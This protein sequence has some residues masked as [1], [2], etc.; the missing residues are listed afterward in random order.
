[1]KVEYLVL[2]QADQK[3]CRSLNTLNYLIQSYDGIQIV[4][5]KV[6]YAHCQFDYEVKLGQ[7]EH[8]EHRFF[9]IQTVCRNEADVANFQEFL[10]LLRT[11]LSKISGRPV[12]ILC[13]EFGSQRCYTALFV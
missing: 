9:H 2:I 6:V 5:D 13:D 11:I 4:Q 12:E 1:M 10:K 7:P 8:A 3:Y